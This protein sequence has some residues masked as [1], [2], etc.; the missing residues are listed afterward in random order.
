MVK[1]DFFGIM[2]NFLKANI[3]LE[4]KTDLVFGKVLEEIL[5]RDNGV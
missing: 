3:N 2:D 5:M 4:Q 1:E